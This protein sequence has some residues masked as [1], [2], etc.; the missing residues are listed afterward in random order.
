[1][2]DITL[3][4]LA[5]ETAANFPGVHADHVRYLVQSVMDGMLDIME[6]KRGRIRLQKC[7]IHTIYYEISPKEMRAR[8]ADLDESREL[9]EEEERLSKLIHLET[10]ILPRKIKW[11][12]RRLKRIHSPRP[13]TDDIYPEQGAKRS[14]GD[15]QKP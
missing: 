15:V 7:D 6:N 14:V 3:K 9:T 5:D 8:M 4:E 1:M 11:L 12:N 2:R 13:Y 10:K